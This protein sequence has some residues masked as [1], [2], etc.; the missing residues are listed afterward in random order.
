VA[1]LTLEPETRGA[2]D[3]GTA[4]VNNSYSIASAEEVSLP[5]LRLQQMTLTGPLRLWSIFANMWFEAVD[6]LLGNVDKAVSKLPSLPLPDAKHLLVPAVSLQP[7]SLII[8]TPP[9]LVGIRVI[10]FP[11][12]PPIFDASGRQYLGRCGS[13]CVPVLSTLTVNVKGCKMAE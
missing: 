8:I 6:S 13:C 5:T 4:G 1:H 11:I 3:G 2:S 10:R 9:V 7:A 12:F